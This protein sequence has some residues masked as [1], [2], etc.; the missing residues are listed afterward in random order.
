MLKTVLKLVVGN[1]RRTLS[2]NFNLRTEIK[3][4]INID[5]FD[6]AR[7]QLE[8]FALNFSSCNPF[9]SKPSAAKDA[10]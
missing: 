6:D 1:S 5:F 2:L 9:P 3:Q 4:A 7:K 10:C 8:K